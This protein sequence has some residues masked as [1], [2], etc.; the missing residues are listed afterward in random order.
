MCHYNTGLEAKLLYTSRCPQMT[1]R[2][3]LPASRVGAKSCHGFEN[4]SGSDAPVEVGDCLHGVEGD[5][6]WLSSYFLFQAAAREND[7]HFRFFV[8]L[9][10]L[11]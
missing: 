2:I 10:N 9:H 4:R 11:I 7:V 3:V 1:S 8:A 6:T 5:K